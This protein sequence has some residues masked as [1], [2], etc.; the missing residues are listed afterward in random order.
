MK[1]S[2]WYSMSRSPQLIIVSLWSRPAA[3]LLD[4]AFPCDCVCPQGCTERFVCSPNEVMEAIE[5]GKNNRSVA[6]TSEFIHWAPS[7]WLGLMGST[8]LG[9]LTAARLPSA[10][11]LCV[12]PTQQNKWCRKVFLPCLNCGK[13]EINHSLWYIVWFLLIFKL[14]VSSVY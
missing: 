8:S 5:D 2:V 10:K 3:G 1:A 4:T 6:V 9:L 11:T 12:R 13:S 7:V 14:K